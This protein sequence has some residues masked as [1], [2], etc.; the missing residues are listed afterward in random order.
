M[1]NDWCYIKDSGNF[2]VKIMNVG[3]IPEN[4]MLV[5]ADAVELYPN[6][7]HNAGPKAF[8]NMLEAREN[9]AVS[10]DDLVKTTR[11]VFGKYFE[12]N[13][14][15]NKQISETAISTKFD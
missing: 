6:I 15:V 12:F 4:G 10:T 9:K 13:G 2:L 11:F 14:D 5:T 1:Q 3:N 8:R 7:S